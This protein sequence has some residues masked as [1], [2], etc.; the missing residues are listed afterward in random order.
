MLTALAAAPMHGHR[1]RFEVEDLS[2]RPVGPGTLYGAI[3][4]LEDDGLI[5]PL[6]PKERRKPYEITDAGRRHL[7]AKIAASRTLV[8]IAEERLGFEIGMAT[9][10]STCWLAQRGPSGI[11][12]TWP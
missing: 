10:S 3:S 1:I 8:Q 6:P 11:A 4:R 5:R 7:A 12:L 2:A 9:N